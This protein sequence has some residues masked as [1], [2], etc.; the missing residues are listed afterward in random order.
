MPWRIIF[1]IISW[2]LEHCQSRQLSGGAGRHEA[3]EAWLKTTLKSSVPLLWRSPVRGYEPRQYFDR[4]DFSHLFG[5]NTVEV[6]SVLSAAVSDI[7]EMVIR[8]TGR[9]RQGDGEG[10]KSGRFAHICADRFFCVSIRTERKTRK[11]ATNMELTYTMQ[12]II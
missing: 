6:I 2:S 5:F 12:G 8:E 3:L 7:S 1:Q 10:R 11:G 9:N 4:E